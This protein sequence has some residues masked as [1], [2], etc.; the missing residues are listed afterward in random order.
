M[1]LHIIKIKMH[2]IAWT[3]CCK[4]ME[5]LLQLYRVKYNL[6]QLDSKSEMIADFGVILNS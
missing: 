6:N 5:F 1:L 3:K 2:A 4:M